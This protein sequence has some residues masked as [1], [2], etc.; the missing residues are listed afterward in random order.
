MVAHT[1]VVYDGYNWLHGDGPRRV[2]DRAVCEYGKRVRL[3]G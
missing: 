2:A 3:G 1:S